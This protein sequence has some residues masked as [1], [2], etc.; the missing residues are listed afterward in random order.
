MFGK[1]VLKKMPG[2]Q[3]SASYFNLG[4]RY[5]HFNTLIIIIIIIIIIFHIL[6][7]ALSI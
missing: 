2:Y 7:S 3:R 5:L 6:Y 1:S 4:V